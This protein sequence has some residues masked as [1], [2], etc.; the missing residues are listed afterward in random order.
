MQTG[1]DGLVGPYVVPP[2]LSLGTI[3][4]GWFSIFQPT[5]RAYSELVVMLRFIVDFVILNKSVGWRTTNREGGENGTES[6][7][8][9][10]K[11]GKIQGERSSK[12]KTKTI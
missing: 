8:G 9:G 3:G 7:G 10:K 2:P 5:S 6:R 12:K 11:N 1:K 4:E